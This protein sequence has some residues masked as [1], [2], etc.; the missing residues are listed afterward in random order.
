ML[1]WLAAVSTTSALA[2]HDT[3]VQQVGAVGVDGTVGPT[4]DV[5]APRLEAQATFSWQTFGRMQHA[6]TRYGDADPTVTVEQYTLSAALRL[7]SKTHLG[8]AL[9]VGRI[10]QATPGP[11][12]IGDA[13]LAVSQGIGAF[14][15]G[16]LAL[17]PTGRTTLDPVSSV[18]DVVPDGDTLIAR[19]FDARASLGAGAW[20]TGLSAAWRG[21]TGW[22]TTTLRT[23]LMTPVA[24]TA[25]GIFWGTDATARA[26]LTVRALAGRLSVGTAVQGQLHT[27]DRIDGEID[28]TTGEPTRLR[29]GR[30]RSLGVLGSVGGR[31]AKGL[32]CGAQAH[33]PVAQWVQGVQLAE[34][35]TVSAQC[36]VG[37]GFGTRG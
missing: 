20:R 7:P 19:T 37:Y 15:I 27:A 32:S 5:A 36:T 26:G 2:H 12:G 3:A 11:V 10:R 22:L 34:S 21:E 28:A 33:V 29:T 18:I 24:P 13:S 14:R 8:I 9:P 23:A 6:G 17:A 16:A 25:D 30:R 1:P 4:L 31:L 35:F